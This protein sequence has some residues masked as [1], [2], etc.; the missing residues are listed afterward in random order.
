VTE[1]ARVL[2][3]ATVLASSGFG[4]YVWRLLQIPSTEP[5][6]LIGELRFAHWM[7]LTLAAVGGAWIGLAAGRQTQVLSGID[8]TLAIAMVLTAAFTLQRDVRGALTILCVAFLTHAIIDA[9]HRPNLMPGDIAP[10]WF[11]LGCA[12]YNLYLSA[13]CYLV[14]RR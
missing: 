14:Q 4:V 12:A 13:L 6:R 8:L 3:V 1:T 2:L 10:R 5:E 11:T 7:A 9:A